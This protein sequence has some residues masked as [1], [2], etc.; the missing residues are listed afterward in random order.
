MGM[1]WILYALPGAGSFHTS[2]NSTSSRP[3]YSDFSSLR[4]GAIILQ[5]MHLS[6][7]R[8]MSLGSFADSAAK[9]AAATKTNADY[10]RVS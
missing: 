1:S 7:P 6:A 9:S 4:T 5:G 10:E 2:M 3:A 8:S